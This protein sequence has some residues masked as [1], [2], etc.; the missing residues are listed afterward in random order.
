VVLAAASVKPRP[1]L[2]KTFLDLVPALVSVSCNNHRVFRLWLVTLASPLAF[3]SPPAEAAGL[4]PARRAA[5]ETTLRQLAAEGRAT[6]GIHFKDLASGTRI[7]I[8]ADRT[9]HAASLVKVPVM[10]EALRRVDEGGWRLEDELPVVNE[11][12]SL[13]DGSL[14]ALGL[15]P[16]TE[17]P[18]AAKIG[19]RATLAFLLTEMIARS[20]NLAANVLLSR[21]GP[22]SV[23]R[24]VDALGAR[25]V[26]VRRCFEDDK[27]FEK[28]IN[29]ETDA[30]GMGAILEAARRSEKL[31]ATARAEAWRLLTR[32]LF[33]DQ[34]PAGL[35][36]DSGAVV[37]HKT[38]TIS[39]VQHDAAIVRLPDG[40]EY[41][42]V[43]L[44]TDF[45][46]NEEGRAAV[47]ETTRRM[48]RA[49]YDAVR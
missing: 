42:L 19:R 13:V 29:N 41:V 3:L 40:R 21:L 5:L 33:N 39:S 34:I 17:G 44:A 6:Y 2:V 48:S 15:D 49:V 30:A 12:G 38:G 25:S 4:P 10:L 28:G 35:P 14:F 27:A 43:L 11:F 36:P 22:E 24:L 8:G 23:Q 7:E 45:G 37:G 20:S 31:S 26:K 46:A 1:R 32:Q 47:K 18:T 16:E 9:M